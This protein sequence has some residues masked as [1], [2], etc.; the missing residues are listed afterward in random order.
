MKRAIVVCLSILLLLAS[1]RGGA[2]GRLAD[3]EKA[4]ADLTRRVK[5]L[6]DQ[7]L[8]ADKKLIRHDQALHAMAERLREMESA[9]NKI[10]LGPTR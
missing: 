5:A 2:G 3:L 4:N 6:E 7:Q 8:E 10:Q 1:C 9:V